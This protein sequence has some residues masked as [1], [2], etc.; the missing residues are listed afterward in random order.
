MESDIARIA[1]DRLPLHP[2]KLRWLLWLRWRLFTRGF[3]RSSSQ[4]VAFLIS[5][6]FTLIVFGGG[7]I[8]SFLAYRFLPPP[9]NLEV[10][11]VVLSGVLLWW[12]LFPIIG[13][14][15]NE[16][17]DVS[18][19]MQFPLTRWEVMAGLLIANV[20]DFSTLILLLVFLAM[21]FGLPTSP[22]MAIMI[23]PAI[24]VFY[25]VLLG[26]SQLFIGLLSSLL[27]NRRLRDLSYLLIIVFTSSCYLFEQLA[28][29]GVSFASTSVLASRPFS[30][31]LQW[32]PSGWVAH[33]IEAGLSGNWLAYGGW[34]LLALLVGV[35][36]LYLWQRLIERTLTASETPAS[37]RARRRAQTMVAPPVP[38]HPRA[39]AAGG[40]SLEAAPGR[41]FAPQ[42]GQ[43]A[44]SRLLPAEIVALAKKEFKY[45]R[46]DPVTYATFLQSLIFTVV[47]VILILFQ[48]SQDG[49][50]ASSFLFYI[51]L[52]VSLLTLSLAINSLGI[53]RNALATLFLFPIKPERMLFGKNLAVATLAVA[54]LLL[55]LLVLTPLTGGWSLFG[56][57]LFGT[58]AAIGVIL[59]CCNVASVLFPQPVYQMRGFIAGGSNPY[60]GAGCFRSVMVL[61]IL[62]ITCI[63]L[64]PIGLAL[65]LPTWLSLP[66]L[67]WIAALCSL[68]YGILF[69]QIATRL[70]APRILT[71]GPEILE[72]VARI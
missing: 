65:A 30:R 21:L 68:A 62:I 4:V 58:L 47:P 40:A 49:V 28:V 44:L 22:L 52:V 43:S 71:R 53:E 5:L 56:P 12:I 14:G 64:V 48:S 2:E 23:V 54:A 18:K 67:F 9:A 19:L 39:A 11:Y 45:Y 6:I 16:S 38:S 59:G 1:P 69:H 66:W 24:V 15:L 29:R 17:L 10:L 33:A 72:I 61:L 36:L 41:S 13:Y 37:R 70:V 25:V 63:L 3:T 60:S 20:I 42:V 55:F 31:Y 34:L 8:A 46:R 7:A 32:L 26:C 35:L 50:P 51:P 27:Q 57:I